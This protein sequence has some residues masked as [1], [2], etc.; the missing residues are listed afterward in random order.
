MTLET[1]REA[2]SAA[3]IDAR[4]LRVRLG[5]LFSSSREDCDGR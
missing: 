2:D 5:S 3:V 4:R 1:T